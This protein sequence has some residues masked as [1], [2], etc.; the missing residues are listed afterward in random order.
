MSTTKGV[1]I[2]EINGWKAW[3]NV[4]QSIGDFRNLIKEIFTKESLS[5]IEEI[6]N[7]TPG[8]NAVFRVG[9]YVIK[10]FAPEEAG[11]NSDAD[12]NAEMQ[13]M[14]RTIAMGINTPKIIAASSI[15]DY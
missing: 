14:Q 10:I 7:L 8:T 9:S 4:F 15:Q 2:K 6:A 13:A 1:F 11:V 3:G 5:D 12:F